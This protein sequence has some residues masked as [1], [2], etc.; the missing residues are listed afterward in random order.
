MID[1]EYCM[2]EFG[3]R[4]IERFCDAGIPDSP[5]TILAHCLHLND[6]EKKLV[7]E[8]NAYIVQNTESNINNNVEIGRAHV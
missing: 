5:K 7:K 4:V 8:S 2:K 6:D 1:Q 3:K